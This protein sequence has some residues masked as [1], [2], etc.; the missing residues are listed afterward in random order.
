MARFDPGDLISAGLR[1]LCAG[2]EQAE[3]GPMDRY[4]SDKVE[5]LEAGRTVG[6]LDFVVV[7][8]CK[9]EYAV[10]HHYLATDLHP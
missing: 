3:C 10:K 2:R 7:A 9:V 5:F 4:Y 1:A 8:K 6:G